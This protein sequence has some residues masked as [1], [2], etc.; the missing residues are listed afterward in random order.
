MGRPVFATG[1]L[2]ATEP[3]DIRSGSI[4]GVYNG[5]GDVRCF[6]GVPFAAPPLGD[7]RWRAPQSP[8]S[9]DGVYRADHFPPA[10]MQSIRGAMLGLQDFAVTDEVSE[11]CLYLNVWTSAGDD[12][13]KRPVLVFFYGGGFVTGSGSQVVYDG[14]TMAQNGVVYVTVN[15]RLG[16]FGFLAHPDL[17]AEAEYH[18]SGN[19]G[20][21]DQLAAL[22]WIHDNIAAFGGDAD[23]VTIA[24]E[25]AG[26]KS[27][28]IFVCS[29][30][31]KGL[32][33]RG[34]SESSCIFGTPS[35]APAALHMVARLAH[36]ETRGRAFTD[37]MGLSIAQLRSLPAQDLLAATAKLGEELGRPLIDGYLLPD[38]A[39]NIFEQ[40]TYNNVPIIVGSN[41][42]ETG[43][44]RERAEQW[45]THFDKEGHDARIAQVFGD[46]ADEY[47]EFYPSD[48]L[49]QA[50]ESYLQYFTDHS[51]TWQTFTWPRMQAKTEDAA[52]VYTY[53]F[54]RV[55]EASPEEIKKLGAHHGAEIAYA[56]GNLHYSGR[57][58]NGVDDALSSQMQAYWVNFARTG[59]PNGDKLPEWEPYAISGQCME[60]GSRV[61][62]IPAPRPD[63]LDFIDRYEARQREQAVKNQTRCIER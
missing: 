1:S 23:N 51:Y 21:L 29:P 42:Q 41:A 45:C 33:H 62:V 9:W 13:E 20:L 31:A 2:R 53:Y 22:Q 27:V 38:S 24:G 12:G 7:L 54:T 3:V 25:S 37:S 32:F 61:Q 18:A 59:N 26:G 8:A 6:A 57:V 5:Q 10:P 58:C 40:G 63:A 44:L 52:P 15:Y 49:Q 50:F 11:D 28:H 39:W 19:Y 60:F 30:L 43:L 56:Y 17:T 34:I 14:E 48:T 55:P 35:A 46:M 36:G 16:A 47:H 4:S